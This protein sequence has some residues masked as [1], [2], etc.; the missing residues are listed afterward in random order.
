MNEFIHVNTDKE[1]WREV[2]GDYYSPSIHVTV[3]RQIGINVGGYVFVKDVREWHGL[4]RKKDEE[5]GN[6]EAR[7]SVTDLL[8]NLARRVSSLEQQLKDTQRNVERQA[9]ELANA[10]HLTES[11]EQDIAMLDERTQPLVSKPESEWLTFGE[12]LDR[13]SIGDKAVPDDKAYATVTRTHM[14]LR[15]VDRM[16]GE[17][18][19]GF[20]PIT[21]SLFRL[22]YKIIRGGDFR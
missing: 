18:W 4:A 2:G 5:E 16:T 15:V 17:T 19:D 22:K 6:V 12:M 7:P 21:Y 11:N 10:K 20:V 8:A 3:N 13:I 1:I 14:G 9:E